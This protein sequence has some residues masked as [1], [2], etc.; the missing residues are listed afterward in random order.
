MCKKQIYISLLHR[1]VALNAL[2]KRNQT[3]VEIKYH[4][5]YISLCNFQCSTALTA[6]INSFDG[7]IIKFVG[8][9]KTRSFLNLCT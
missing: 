2:T 9:D 7:S 1:V 4:R 6:Y 5:N 3:A 8:H